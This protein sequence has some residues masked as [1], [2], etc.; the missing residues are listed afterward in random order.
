LSDE[1]GELDSQIQKINDSL[2][3]YRQEVSTN[4]GSFVGDNG[5]LLQS[6]SKDIDSMN[7]SQL[8]NIRDLLIATLNSSHDGNLG[9]NKWATALD[10]DVDQVAARD[11]HNSSVGETARKAGNAHGVTSVTE[12]SDEDRTNDV[13]LSQFGDGVNPS[14]AKSKKHK[15]QA[16]QGPGQDLMHLTEQTVDPDNQDP[17]NYDPSLYGAKFSGAA[18][19]KVKKLGIST[20]LGHITDTDMNTPLQGRIEHKNGNEAEISP[21]EPFKSAEN[22]QTKLRAILQAK[23]GF[24]LKFAGESVQQSHGSLES[25][26]LLRHSTEPMMAKDRSGSGGR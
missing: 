10:L 17:N 18:K 3:A 14:G 25:E 24:K 21:R 16:A 19:E 20:D 1:F 23:E 8:P 13:K 9:K 5:L 22:S 26:A 6:I 11:A 15:K 2:F 12:R 7:L 4:G